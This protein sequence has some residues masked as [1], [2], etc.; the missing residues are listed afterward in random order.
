MQ[1]GNVNSLGRGE[2]P[3]YN[4]WLRKF[5]FDSP[6]AMPWYGFSRLLAPSWDWVQVEVTTHCQAAC[7]YCPR[8]VYRASW[9]DR[10]I[11]LETFRRLLPDLKW[12]RLVY[13]QGWGE[14][15]LHPE[16]FTMA[17][18]AKE[19]GCRVG[20]TTNGMLLDAALG[21][22]IVESGLDV[23]AFSLAGL[24]E[25]NDRVRR[26]TRFAT[27]LEN[28]RLL[29]R[30][31]KRRGASRP[32]L[33]LAYMLLGSGLPDLA[34]L[35]EALAGSG[36][37]QVVVSTL[38][39]AATS[40]LAEESLRLAGPGEYRDLIFELDDLAAR[41]RRRGLTISHYLAPPG[42]LWPQC[43][44]NAGRAA[45]VAA[46]GLVSPCVYLNLPVA[47]ETSVGLGGEQPY[48][49]Q[50]F[51]HLPLHSLGD[52]WRLSAYRSFRRDLRRGALP[53]WC[54]NCLKVKTPRF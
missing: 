36:V 23:L 49:R 11:S 10:H 41:G 18:L 33:H 37:E 47:G 39:F 45:V 26:G 16:F 42:R 7:T 31:K 14:P 21:A 44:E 13:L 22:R 29:E 25:R 15:F 35:P 17:A 24:G 28:I 48:V 34:L 50:G 43:P 51:G 6:N 54:R 19:A 46:D 2:E 12:A 3:L 40:E 8:T 30:L 9:E 52:L 20:A 27:V 32:V 5:L 1:A 4:T 53:A 38:D